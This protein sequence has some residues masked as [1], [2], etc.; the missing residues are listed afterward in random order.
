LR[1]P[2][3]A[4]A[5]SWPLGGVPRR[6][7]SCEIAN[8]LTRQGEVSGAGRAGEFADLLT[9]QRVPEPLP[10]STVSSPSHTQSVVVA[11]AATAPCGRRRWRG[12]GGASRSPQDP[13]FVCSRGLDCVQHLASPACHSD[14]AK[15]LTRLPPLGRIGSPPLG[16]DPGR[17][18]RRQAAFAF[19]GPRQREGMRSHLS[20]REVHLPSL[21]L[22]NIILQ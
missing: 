17:E 12:A 2:V 13:R 8:L 15:R 5:A 21:F 10:T 6:G 22:D 9:R 1:E 16:C 7:P 19:P 18:G 4:V 3:L 20:P 14:L 11:T